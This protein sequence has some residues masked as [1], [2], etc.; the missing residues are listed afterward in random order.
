M[1]VRPATVLIWLR[2]SVQFLSQFE[3]LYQGFMKAHSRIIHEDVQLA[4]IYLGDFFMAPFNAF[5]VG[6]IQRNGAHP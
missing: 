1:G 3:L 4:A 2:L 6:D 5:G